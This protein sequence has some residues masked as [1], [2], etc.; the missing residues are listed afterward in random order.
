MFK[1]NT[2]YLKFF[3]QKFAKKIS[4]LFRIIFKNKSNKDD[5]L[6]FVKTK[7]SDDK[8]HFN[9]IIWI[10]F[11]FACGCIFYIKFSE[12][13]VK[14]IIIFIGFFIIAVTLFLADIFNKKSAIYLF[15]IS[16]LLGSFY[17]YFYEKTFLNYSKITEKIYTKN[18]GKIIAIK[19][20]NN[21]INNQNGINLIIENPIISRINPDESIYKTKTKSLNKKTK[22][23]K[24]KI[25]KKKTKKKINK[26]KLE[27]NSR[28]TQEKTKKK[29]SEKKSKKNNSTKKK[30]QKKNLN[31]NKISKTKFKN[32]VNLKD[33]QEIDRVFLD[34]Q[35]NYQNYH[36]LKVKDNLQLA[37]PPPH[38]SVN[39]TNNFYDLKINDKIKFFSLLQPSKSKDFLDDFDHQI[40]GKL[41]KLSGYGY[42]IGN[43]EIIEHSPKITHE[44]FFRNLRQIIGKKILNILPNNEGGIAL[45]LLIGDQSNISRELL[46]KIRNCGLSHLLSISGF[47]LSLASLIFFMLFRFILSHFPAI[48]LRYDLKKIS[49]IF[50][51]MASYFYLKIAG[52]PIPAQRA[53]LM[54]LLLQLSYFISERFNSKRAL[55]LSF[56]ILTLFNPYLLFNLS[57]QLSFISIMIMICYYHDY[58]LNKTN[59]EITLEGIQEKKFFFNRLVRF[60]A[61]IYHYLKEIIVISTII[62][63]A[64]LPFLMNAF[65]NFSLIAP[66]SNI[67]A[68]PLTSFVI[69]PL[70]FLSLFLM[71]F[72]LENYG[73]LIMKLGIFLL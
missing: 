56:F 55:M 37:K 47:H 44:D 71:I 67:F 49:A 7:F 64:T 59:Q 52:T 15:V 6:N 24:K 66:I 54:V 14:E 34:Y 18:E 58:V 32:L 61:K 16:F 28:K 38:I 11:F 13:F 39:L 48:A 45:A 29:N 4:S 31:F 33:Y 53:F 50:A 73:L 26:K 40:D 57:F 9:P 46:Q 63:I 20:F 72:N 51:L 68:I 36:W 65:H 21:P 27:K 23:K 8:N 3:L 70:G 43:I 17:N 62:Q 35:K 2:N 41:K 10:A 69:M 12:N 60:I 30:S 22:T 19:K 5:N 42:V 25:K 1:I